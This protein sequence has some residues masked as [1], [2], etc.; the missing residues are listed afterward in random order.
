MP[1]G[2][3]WSFV[4]ENPSD[5]DVT[6]WNILQRKLQER[7]SIR[8]ISFFREHTIEPILIKGLAASFNYPK[9]HF[10]NSADVDLAFSPEDFEAAAKISLAEYPKGVSADLH[11]GLRHL[12]TVEWG[13]LFENSVLIE[14]DGFPI[15]MLRPEDHLRVLCVHWLNDG[16]GYKE[17]LWDVYY[18]VANRS[19][20][21]DWDRCINVVSETRQGWII[22]AIGLAHRYLALDID[23]LPF[24]DQAR[25]I[26]SWLIRGVEI[27]WSSN[28][29][30]ASLHWFLRDPR[31]LFAQIKKRI[32]PNPIQATIEMEG[33]FDDGSRIPYQIRNTFRRIVPSIKKIS[34]SLFGKQN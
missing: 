29:R 13:D 17:R 15:R 12:D 34:Q 4:R 14:V 11:R 16:G 27:E 10:R 3:F 33:R 6:R 2:F 22:A 9:H 18:A 24:A 26:P 20:D 1:F 23:D 25:S 30:L 7:N 8:A 32:P 31:A 28:V 5:P 21:F 19:I